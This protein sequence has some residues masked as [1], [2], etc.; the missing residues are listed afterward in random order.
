M[1]VSCTFL[2]VVD[3]VTNL[4]ILPSNLR[5]FSRLPPELQIYIYQYLH[6]DVKVYY[7]LDKYNW[8]EAKDQLKNKECLHQT[9]QKV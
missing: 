3:L 7:W 1:Y 4:L 5:N 2:Y 8:K 6:D 9:H